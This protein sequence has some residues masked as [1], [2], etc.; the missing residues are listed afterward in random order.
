[1][2]N[3]LR[4]L[5]FT[6]SF[7]G[8][9]TGAV[10]AE[11][12]DDFETPG[13]LVT[14]TRIGSFPGPTITTN[15]P[16]MTN[17]FL[18]LIHDGVGN[19][20]NHYTYDLT[21]TGAFANVEAWWDF[22]GN[23]VGNAGADGYHFML[24]PT[25]DY[26]ISGDGPR[27]TAEEPNTVNAFGVGVDYHP[28]TAVNDLSMHWNGVEHMNSRPPTT[29]L[30][31]DKPE[32][33]RA[34]LTIESM[35]NS[36][37]A[38]LEVTPEVLTT[39]A[40]ATFVVWESIVPMMLPFESR[41]QFGA[42]SGGADMDVDIDNIRVTW[43]NEYLTPPMAI[44]TNRLYQD[45]DLSGATFFSVGQFVSPTAAVPRPGPLPRD[46]EPGRGV[47]LRLLHD[48]VNSGRNAITFDH[49]GPM[50]EPAH[51]YG[52]DFRMTSQV[53][54]ADGLG[55]SF[56]PLATYGTRGGG[57]INASNEEPNTAGT[58]AIGIDLHDEA[59]G[60][61]DISVHFDGLEK[62]NLTLD[63][64][65]IFDW[66]TGVWSRLEI[67]V[68]TVSNGTEV[69][70]FILPDIEGTNNLVAITAIDRFVVTNLP[71]LYAHRLMI[72]SRSGG[73]F[74]DVDIDN[75]TS[76][77]ADP[78]LL[79]LSTA[80]DFD[81]AEENWHAVWA[82][83]GG[84]KVPPPVIQDDS[85]PNGRY[86]RLVHDVGNQ[87]NSLVF[88]QSTDG[89]NVATNAITTAEFDF[90][91]SS[92]ATNNPA[93]GFAFLLIP[94]DTYGTTG[95]G[96][97]QSFPGTEIEAPF[98]A[99]VLAI[100]VDVHDENLG[101][102]DI[103]LYWDNALIE[104]I[105]LPNSTVDLDDGF[106]HHLTCTVAW[107]STGSL[108]TVSMSTNTFGT[109]G[110]TTN[111]FTQFIP[112]LTPY[113]YRV[114]FA[115]R[116]AGAF[117]NLDLDNIAVSTTG[118]T[119]PDS[120]MDDLLDA[121][122][123]MFFTNITWTAGSPGEDFD[124]DGFDDRSEFLA[125]TDPTDPASLLAIRAE[126]V[127]GGQQLG[128]DSVDGITYRLWRAPNTFTPWSVL[129]SGIQATAPLNTYFDASNLQ[130]QLLYRVE[131]EVVP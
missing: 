48:N 41:V 14:S 114:E 2:K 45:F 29:D 4:L 23:S 43:T 52:F 21:D 108:V 36:S 35:G 111:M 18:R 7:I 83:N 128:W 34:H 30:D 78:D 97:H 57:P 37:I 81:T 1:M 103:G 67:Q 92:A 129:Q 53:F 121:W 38:K 22:R 80:Q 126:R 32:F 122:E 112:T 106:F 12:V 124:Q 68:D 24:I 42:R 104:K 116:T 28:A 10:H 91:V 89:Q 98:I 118:G 6:L 63:P 54:A 101:V 76:T 50:L 84:V 40:G 72:G 55:I 119:N 47:Y 59:T 66:N 17:S 20:S 73:R 5:T 120:D 105:T 27:P 74:M 107:S 39:N 77:N 61:N 93:D 62:L 58:L 95:P 75:I 115:G 125:G 25:S 71:S 100:G 11:L 64:A 117:I 86:L 90:R 13:P 123:L 8:L 79:A 96:A 51:R 44:V 87:Q 130:T 113:D 9:L 56:L 82:K 46:D 131:V 26:G 15:S 31:I 99:D 109:A 127:P 70:V 110:V 85:Q 60:T 16:S 94:T 33:H 102:N 49:A 19:N 65:T 3:T 88:N 69:S